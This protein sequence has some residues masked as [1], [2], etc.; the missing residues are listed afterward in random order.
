MGKQLISVCVSSTRRKVSLQQP[1]G[2]SFPTNLEFLSCKPNDVQESE[3]T[4]KAPS[5][6][7]RLYFACC[8]AF[9]LRH[10]S[11]EK[12]ASQ[13]TFSFG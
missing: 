13:S 5:I 6:T 4:R 2:V 9:R 8:L 7:R 10:G 11:K 3:V 12:Y 1:S